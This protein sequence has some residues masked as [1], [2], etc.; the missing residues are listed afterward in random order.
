MALALATKFAGKVATLRA[1]YHTA[2][3]FGGTTTAE[4]TA[5]LNQLQNDATASGLSFEQ[6]LAE[7]IV[8]ADLSFA[9]SLV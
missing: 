1:Y 7:N 8:K 2:F 9:Q 4:I 3:S 6:L 5:D